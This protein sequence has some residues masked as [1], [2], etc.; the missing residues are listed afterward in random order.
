MSPIK[1]EGNKYINVATNLQVKNK[2]TLEYIKSLRIPPA[3]TNVVINDKNSKILAYG[4]DSKGRKQTIYSKWFIERQ[5][6]KRFDRIIKL[7]D[8]FAKIQRDILKNMKRMC[9]CKK[10]AGAGA[11]VDTID[12]K[13]LISLILQIMILCNFRIGCEKYARENNSYGLT[14]LEWKHIHF[15]SSRKVVIKF[16]GKKGVENEADLRDKYAIRCLKML[17]DG[18]NN[19]RVFRYYDKYY[20]KKNSG[21]DEV[22]VPEP[23]P[24]YIRASDVNKF[25]QKYDPDLTCKDIRTAMANYLY[26]KFYNENTAE[27]NPKKRQIAA[28]KRVAEELHNTPAVCKSS[29]IN[30]AILKY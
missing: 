13:G 28:I 9:M 27:E 23:V 3:Y 20:D 14:T 18:P 17:A 1:K 24:H 10:C 2:N 30:P 5:R 15:V 25:L 7:N 21:R 8:I 29:Y 6:A 26:I 22:S 12:K 16:I 4:Y 19:T 11:G